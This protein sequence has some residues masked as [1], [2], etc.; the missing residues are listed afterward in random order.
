MFADA[1]PEDNGFRVGVVGGKDFYRSLPLRCPLWITS[2]WQAKL[3]VVYAVAKMA[4]YRGFKNVRG[5]LKRSA[6]AVQPF[7]RLVAV[8][9][10]TLWCFGHHCCLV[11]GFDALGI[12]H[13]Q[14]FT[15]FHPFLPFCTH[16]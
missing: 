2:L 11:V 12:W 7:G 5:R 4:T 1:A 8:E 14:M 15:L 13:F 16:F 9:T 3:F 6:R 10:H